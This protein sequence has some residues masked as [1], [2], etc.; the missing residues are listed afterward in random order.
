MQALKGERPAWFEESNGFVKT[1]VYDGDKLM[2]G[3]ILEGPCIVEE[4]MTNV[5]IP[6]GAKMLVDDYANY[7]TA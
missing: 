5:I 3:N 7:I 6:P 4:R 2:S 1:K